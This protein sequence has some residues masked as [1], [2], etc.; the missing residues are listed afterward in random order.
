MVKWILWHLKGMIDVFLVYG[1]NAQHMYMVGL[2]D[3]DHE[4]DIEI[5]RSLAVGIV[6]SLLLKMEKP[7]TFYQRL[8]IQKSNVK[9]NPEEMVTR[10]FPGEKF[11]LFLDLID[12]CRR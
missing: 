7:I 11:K 8:C 1:A 9:E 3:S 6:Q 4:R 12:V 5:R 10:S 2:I